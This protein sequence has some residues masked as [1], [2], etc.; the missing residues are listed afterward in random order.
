MATNVLSE[1]SA[2]LDE[3]TLERLANE[4]Q[5]PSIQVTY[6][7]ELC[8][9]QILERLVRHNSES[10][11]GLRT[12]HATISEFQGAL[13]AGIRTVRSFTTT[14][15][16]GTN[17]LREILGGD[18]TELVDEVA[19]SADVDQEVAEGIL[20]I[21]SAV[22]LDVLGRYRATFSLDMH[23]LADLICTQTGATGEPPMRTTGTECITSTQP[24]E[25]DMNTIPI[26]IPIQP[27]G[28]AKP[29]KSSDA[30]AAAPE[31]PSP[32]QATDV[33][34]KLDTISPD[35]LN[36]L[37]VTNLPKVDR[38]AQSDRPKTAAPEANAEESEKPHVGQP[39][40]GDQRASQTI[41]KL[42]QNRRFFAIAT[43]IALAMA[44]VML[45][46]IWSRSSSDA[47]VAVINQPSGVD[48]PSQVQAPLDHAPD[49]PQSPPVVD[50]PE[51]LVVDHQAVPVSTA[52]PAGAQVE[53]ETTVTELDASPD[54]ADGENA[55]EFD[56]TRLNTASVAELLTVDDWE[57]ETRIV[58]YTL[59]VD[60][61][62]PRRIRR[63]DPVEDSGDLSE[64]PLFSAVLRPQSSATYSW[65][66]ERTAELPPD[67]LRIGPW[68]VHRQ[69]RNRST[70]S[71][72]TY[73]DELQ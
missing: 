61:Y 26:S 19:A 65:D 4:F 14:I 45:F 56:N 70:S 39:S 8:A 17:S 16:L 68:Q 46:R 69:P 1:V 11:E 53:D 54:Q 28:G 29:E 57:F 44:A 5:T 7:V 58:S 24:V 64:D 67:K 21:A 48:L 62:R 73:E 6:G 41:V 37:P 40:R 36:I 47:V 50:R 27:P 63:V 49:S 9:R 43:A 22:T 33:A 66:A 55:S 25:V 72:F 42:L 30:A 60:L 71:Y 20:G 35:E 12:A 51:Q 3:Q 23:G 38:A 52:A 10:E 32:P 13:L 15:H 59:E 18:L 31:V 34:P 2:T